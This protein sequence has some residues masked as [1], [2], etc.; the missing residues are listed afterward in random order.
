MENSENAWV[1]DLT[2][3]SLGELTELDETEIG[4]AV[5]VLKE[6]AAKPLSTIA[7]SSGS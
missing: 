3:I 1:P 2:E 6:R 5:T 4:D 7:G